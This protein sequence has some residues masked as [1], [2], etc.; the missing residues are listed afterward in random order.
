M[1]YKGYLCALHNNIKILFVYGKGI[2]SSLANDMV[3]I[4]QSLFTTE[5]S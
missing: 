5:L 1:V 4:C 3:Y 2:H